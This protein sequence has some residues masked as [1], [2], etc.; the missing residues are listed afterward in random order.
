ME[1]HEPMADERWARQHRAGVEIVRG[2]GP[3]RPD[4]DALRQAAE[5]FEQ[6][7]TVAETFGPGD[8]RLITSLI[9]LLGVLDTAGDGTA[10]AAAR[11]RLQKAFAAF[12]RRPTDSAD[13]QWLLATFARLL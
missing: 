13:W 12:I 7:A 6:A 9:A 3:G 11:S 8:R 5:A 2:L 4:P 10:V 1:T